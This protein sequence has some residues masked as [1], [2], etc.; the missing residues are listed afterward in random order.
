MN[1]QGAALPRSCNLSLCGFVGSS[2]PL[3]VQRL[4]LQPVIRH[5]DA[6]AKPHPRETFGIMEK[7]VKDLGQS[8][9]SAGKVVH[10]VAELHRMALG[11]LVVSVEVIFELLQRARQA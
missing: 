7:V 4:L 8:W 10:G 2:F 1:P 3:L 9:S 11:L 5:I 6:A